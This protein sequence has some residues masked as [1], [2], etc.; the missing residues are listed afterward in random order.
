MVFKL[1]L[2]PGYLRLG[3]APRVI[4]MTGYLTDALALAGLDFLIFN[5]INFY[6]RVF[7]HAPDVMYEN[8]TRFYKEIRR[9]LDPA[10][11]APAV[12]GTV[13]DTGMSTYGILLENL[14]SK[15]A[16]FPTALE[17]MSFLQLSNVLKSLSVLHATFWQSPRF[18]ADLAWIPTPLTGGMEFVFHSI[19]FGLIRDHV[20]SHK[21]EQTLLAPLGLTLKQLWQGLLTAETL[22]TAP[23]VTLCHGDTHI[24]NTYVLPDDRVGLLDW[25]LMSRASW[26]R[27]V[28]YILGTSLSPPQRES[29]EDS[30]LSFY[31]DSLRD[32]LRVR[33][34]QATQ[35]VPSFSEARKLYSQSMAWGLVIGWLICPPINYGEALWS[36]NVRRLVAACRHLD[37]FALLGVQ[38]ISTR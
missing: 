15:G 13:Y 20:R 12:F 16:R 18:E 21:F 7:P 28:S 32:Q 3:A 27:D 25:Q 10:I 35:S 24:Q 14:L 23:P 2:L 29:L 33:G 8:E 30:L 34:L 6:Q 22:L 37:T 4:R 17:E 1:S 36:A 19:G 26:A 38:R 11:E 31:L 9:D 5:A